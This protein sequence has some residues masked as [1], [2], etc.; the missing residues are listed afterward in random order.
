MG[1]LVLA[2]SLTLARASALRCVEHAPVQVAPAYTRGVSSWFWPACRSSPCFSSPAPP[3]TIP[4]A[5]A[6][7]WG[8]RVGN[9]GFVDFRAA[10]TACRSARDTV[11]WSAGARDHLAAAG[12]GGTAHRS[13]ARSDRST[14]SE[15]WR[16]PADAGLGLD[17][18]CRHRTL[19][20]LAAPR[21]VVAGLG[22]DGR[23]ARAG[24]DDSG[25]WHCGLT[26]VMCT[27]F[28][29]T[30]RP[31]SHCWRPLR[32]RRARS[33]R[34]RIPRCLP[35]GR[36][37]RG[38]SV[39]CKTSG[40]TRRQAGSISAP[41]STMATGRRRT[42]WHCV[43]TIHAGGASRPSSWRWRRGTGPDPARP[44]PWRHRASFPSPPDQTRRDS[45]PAGGP[46]WLHPQGYPDPD[47]G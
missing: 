17:P 10:L 42:R 16:S 6:G 30:R 14:G 38:S 41:G 47:A 31:A 44:D 1:G 13:D 15:R 28:S 3:W 39:W 7:P 35:V 9:H 2:T 36:S 20:A 23:S 45:R 29:S 19:S 43:L 32:S 33:R 25:W 12:F 40:V 11:H 24:T 4:L 26:P 21:A 22:A 34:V 8:R 46:A 18:G 27:P 37:P 5:A